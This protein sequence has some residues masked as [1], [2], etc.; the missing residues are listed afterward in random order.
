[1]FT[2]DSSG[3]WPRAGAAWDGFANQPMSTDREDGL[4]LHDAFITAAARC[5]PDNNP[6]QS[7]RP[8]ARS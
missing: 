4:T 6:P 1:M 2:G 7:L 8:A 3:D 5:A